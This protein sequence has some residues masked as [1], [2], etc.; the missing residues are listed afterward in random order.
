MYLCCF[1][2]LSPSHTSDPVPAAL[3]VIATHPDLS[4][5]PAG[6]APQ[7][8]ASQPARFLH[9]SAPQSAA[10]H[11]RA[12]PA[13]WG[14]RCH[15][16]GGA[17]GRG[18]GGAGRVAAD[19]AAAAARSAPPLRCAA[20]APGAAALPQPFLPRAVQVGRRRGAHGV[21]AAAPSGPPFCCQPA[22]AHPA[23]A[24]GSQPVRLPPPPLP[25]RPVP[26]SL[27]LSSVL[28]PSAVLFWVRT[29]W[30]THCE[31]DPALPALPANLNVLVANPL[32]MFLR[33]TDA[34]RCVFRKVLHTFL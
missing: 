30:S 5:I 26:M 32:P 6:A 3:C 7:P 21:T 29:Q 27:S 12:L 4:L 11:L 16:Q 14:C 18:A 19:G 31:C 17:C 8:P 28:A 9:G 1:L 2:S 33:D 25:P 34:V 13:S 23:A 20:G 10:T 15:A 24:L 22:R